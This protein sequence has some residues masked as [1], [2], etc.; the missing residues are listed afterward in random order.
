MNFE[1]KLNLIKKSKQVHSRWYKEKYRDVEILKMNPAAHYLKYGALMGRD[2][3]SNFD[4]TYYKET[5][6]DGTENE[7]MNPLLHYMLTGGKNK[8]KRP[9]SLIVNRE[10]YELVQGFLKRLYVYGFEK[11]AIK[12]LENIRDNSEDLYCIDYASKELA[13]WNYRKRTEEGFNKA[14][15]YVARGPVAK[16][17]K[18]YRSMLFQLEL[19]CLFNLNEIN[20]AKEVLGKVEKENCITTN[21]ILASANLFKPEDEKIEYINKALALNKIAPIA[22]KAEGDTLYDRLVCNENLE[23]FGN[24]M[25]KVSV[26]IACY[27]SEST[28][29]TSLDSL[30]SQTWKN[31]E[32]LVIDDCSTDSTVEIVQEYVQKDS[33]FRLIKMKKNGGAYVARN[34]GLDEA[35]GEFVTLNDADDWSHPQKIAIQANFLI[36]NKEV[37][38]CTSQ[39]ARAT[40]EL[41]FGRVNAAGEIINLNTS[42]FMFKKDIVKEKCGYWDTVRFGADTELLRRIEMATHSKAIRK[43]QTGPL[44]FQRISESSIVGDSHFGIESYNFGARL[45]YREAFSVFHKNNPLK[46]DAN[47]ERAFTAPYPM[48][49]EREKNKKRKF[50]VVIA[51][52][53]R[54]AGGSTRSSIEELICQQRNGVKTA[55][56]QMFSYEFETTRSMFQVLSEYMDLSEIE[57]VNYGE[58]VECDLL[59]IRYPPVL[60]YEQK[61]IPNIKAK[62][63]KVII[64]QTPMSDYS[65]TGKVRFDFKSAALNLKKYF[66]GNATWYPIGPL[67]RDALNVHHKDDLKHI[68]I[69]KHDWSNIIDI[70][71]WVRVRNIPMSKDIIKIGRHSRDNYVKWPNGKDAILEVYP[72]SVNIEVHVLGGAN[73]VVEQI[74]YLPNNWVVYEF[75]QLHPKEFLEKLDV[76]IYYAHPGWVE[77][78][79]RVIIEAMAAGVPVVLPKIYKPLF[80]NAAVYANPEN[81]LQVALDLYANQEMYENQVNLAHHYITNNF[82]Y[83]SHMKRISKYLINE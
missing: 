46:L 16:H 43:L 72:D 79:G 58:E 13:L 50:D 31:I 81:A 55:L 41:I 57:T 8:K 59:I 75:G 61:F 28:I 38:G 51:S 22:L 6:L 53:F 71:S 73:S 34:R 56:M 82:S 40:N 45:T 36:N 4:T 65:E 49:P 12:D 67:V 48:L 80:K 2:P 63:I 20:K 35:S 21:T 54:M 24:E 70:D 29:K 83:S 11:K 37:V 33:R 68:S 39:Q 27:N 44:S 25:P 17:G 69:S 77:S 60:Q 7:K 15:H 9:D 47:G 64:N 14:L 66:N 32:V 23:T 74:G 26:L 42:S 30:V 1:K 10:S 3:G 19:L 5:Y 62:E 52:D 78:F 18:K 76:F